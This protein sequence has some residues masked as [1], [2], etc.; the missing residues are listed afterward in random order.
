MMQNNPPGRK[1]RARLVTAIAVAA[2]IALTGCATAG[3]N[4]DANPSTATEKVRVAYVGSKSSTFEQAAVDGLSSVDGITVD[5]FEVGYDENK[6]QQAIDDA[7]VSGKYQGIITVPRTATGVIPAAERAIEAGLQFVSFAAVL[8]AD[9]ELLEVQIPGQ[10]AAITPDNNAIGEL[11]WEMALQY[12]DEEGIEVCNIARVGAVP[13]NG[14]ERI[15]AP[16]RR[17]GSREGWRKGQSLRHRLRR[18]VG[19]QPRS[20]SGSGLVHS[21]P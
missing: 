7:I 20:D 5:F 11:Q 10:A 15:F 19:L 13:A 18:R 9:D 8:G 17:F 1:R 12:C 4:T 2:T 3:G 21:T 16:G 14:P 6:Q